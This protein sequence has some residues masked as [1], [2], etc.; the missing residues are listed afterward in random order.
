MRTVFLSLFAVALAA[1]A[2]GSPA[3]PATSAPAALPAGA[4]GSSDRF[5]FYADE[6]ESFHHFLYEWA[7]FEK[8]QQI[9]KGAKAAPFAARGELAA[10]APAEQAAWQAALDFYAARI[11]DRALLWDLGLLQLRDHLLGL[12]ELLPSDETNLEAARHLAAT[13]LTYR[14]LFWPR[15]AAAARAWVDAYLALPGLAERERE[16]AARVGPAFGGVFPRERVRVDLSPYADEFGGYT[17]YGP[18]V[19]ISSLDQSYQG[20]A[21]LEMVFHEACHGDLTSEPLRLALEAAYTSR[22]KWPPRPLAHAVHFYSV[23]E[24]ARHAAARR[25]ITYATA[26]DEVIGRAWPQWREPLARHWGPWLEEGGDRETAFAA[27]VDALIAAEPK[28]KDKT[29]S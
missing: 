25:G 4:L 23:G 12:R 29:G 7:R 2:G 8:S 22:G 5:V 10:L 24:I 14:R 26:A 19:V 27:L 16:I 1:C 17:T 15:H 20:E 3:P 6:K 28:P 11:V 9:E 21:S 18:Q 13:A